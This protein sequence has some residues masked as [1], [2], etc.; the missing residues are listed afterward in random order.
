VCQTVRPSEFPSQQRLRSLIA[1]KCCKSA[2]LHTRS[3]DAAHNELA[4]DISAADPD[5][6]A[7][8]AEVDVASMLDGIEEDADRAAMDE[9]MGVEAAAIREMAGGRTMASAASLAATDAKRL[10]FREAALKWIECGLYD[11]FVRG[12][13][14]RQCG[15]HHAHVGATVAGDAYRDGWNTYEASLPPSA[16]CAALAFAA[17]DRSLRASN[18]Q[19]ARTDAATRA[20]VERMPIPG[21]TVDYRGGAR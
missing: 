14:D 16:K 13:D 5:A 20:A 1:A 17:I 15:R 18:D 8:K 19:S 11:F 21:V 12:Y 2:T 9:S 4:T 3:A 6:D 10:A 7:A